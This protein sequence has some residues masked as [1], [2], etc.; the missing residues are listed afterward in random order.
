MRCILI[1]TFSLLTVFCYSQNHHFC[2]THY[3]TANGLSSNS[4]YRIAQDRYGYLW[5]GTYD[6]LDRFDGYSFESFRPD[7]LNRY[8]IKTTNVKQLLSDLN[9]NIWLA[10]KKVTSFDQE[11]ECFIEVPNPMFDDTKINALELDLDYMVDDQQGCLWYMYGSIKNDFFF[12]DPL[13]HKSRKVVMKGIDERCRCFAMNK[14]ENTLWFQYSRSLPALGSMDITQ[15]RKTGKA[16]FK[17]YPLPDV[18][19]YKN[20]RAIDFDIL[21]TVYI[22]TEDMEVYKISKGTTKAVPDER[23]NAVVNACNGKNK[24]A[25]IFRDTHGDFWIKLND[26]GVIWWNPR[27][28]ISEHYL[29]QMS[30]CQINMMFEDRSGCI[31]FATSNGLDCINLNQK[32]F[33]VYKPNA[34]VPAEM[35]PPFFKIYEN[36]KG[37]LFFSTGTGLC[38]YNPLEKRWQ[39]Y[40][41]DMG[42]IKH[43]KFHELHGISD[44]IGDYMLFST[45]A[46]TKIDLGRQIYEYGHPYQNDD[47]SFV[48]WSAWA[49]LHTKSTNEFWFGTTEGLCRLRKPIDDSRTADRGVPVKMP[50]KFEQFHCRLEDSTTIPS[51]FIWSLYEDKQGVVWAGTRN[52]LARYKRETNSFIRYKYDPANPDGISHYKVSC[53]FED[54]KQRFWVGTEYGLNLMD[55]KTGKFKRYYRKDGLPCDIIWGIIEDKRGMLWI[56]TENGI[57]RFDPDREIFIRYD[58]SDG[59][60]ANSNGYRS[61]YGCT[62][63]G[64]IFFGTVGGMVH[65]YPDSIKENTMAPDVIISGLKLSYRTVKI[66]QEFNGDVILSRSVLQT[67]QIEL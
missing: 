16:E 51:D 6:G 14:E 5:L 59:L 45:L 57:C 43:I 56:T 53:M 50:E 62:Q 29:N 39:V 22:S 4:I 25:G 49:L 54:N 27:N 48:G 35:A 2:V 3:S 9:G 52:G 21:G 10:E 30:S 66:G 41:T 32:A 67:K 61:S 18:F 15:Y 38:V 11:K 37:N 34:G 13:H 31:W 24:V 44:F 36:K 7:P 19:K 65:F 42:R 17:I 8:S 26:Y 20:I 47:S 46:V 64:Q 12:Y 63:N 1:L 40:K 55:R 23:I 60:P 33:G 58:A 28:N